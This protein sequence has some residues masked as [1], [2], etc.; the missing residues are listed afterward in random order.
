MWFF[1]YLGILFL[2]I[3]IALFAAWNIYDIAK[4][5]KD[6]G[7]ISILSTEQI[8]RLSAWSVVGLSSIFFMIY[9]LLGFFFYDPKKKHED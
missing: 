8:L 1:K 2:F 7:D 9:S 3:G 6:A 4:F 5:A